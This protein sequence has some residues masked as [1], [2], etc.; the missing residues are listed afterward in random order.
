[1]NRVK[2]RILKSLLTVTA[3]FMAISL[4]A[5]TVRADDYQP[6]RKSSITITLNDI[7][8][9][10]ANVEFAGYQVGRPT[11]EGHLW[12]QLTENFADCKV[13]LNVLNTAE[14]QKEAVKLLEKAVISKKADFAG[15]TDEEGVVFFG[16]L[17]HG[18]YLLRQTEKGSY[19]TVESF[20]VAIPY[21]IDGENWI[22][23]VPVTPKAEPLPPISMPTVTPTP[24]PSATPSVIP[25]VSP[26][27][28]PSITPDKTP[29]IIPG[30]DSGNPPSIHSSGGGHSEEKIP[31]KTGDE[32]PVK[33][34]CLLLVFAAAAGGAIVLL[35]K[36]R[37]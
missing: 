13:D 14:K 37:N 8:S 15:K 31:V 9:Y 29:G 10:K 24:S 18:V 12:W 32:T 5:G 33:S 35:Q 3:V 25:K 16:N 36:K 17:E 4:F 20:L 7:D 19:G 2:N 27:V 34:M 21:M 1:M 30:G 6:D 11:H 22:Y 23:D 26:S 28:T